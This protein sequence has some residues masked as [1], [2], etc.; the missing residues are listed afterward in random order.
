MNLRFPLIFIFFVTFGLF[1]PGV[2][3]A[4]GCCF[5]SFSADHGI[6]G[7]KDA[8]INAS[9]VDP[10]NI[11]NITDYGK[12]LVNEKIDIVIVNPKSGQSC[13]MSSPTTNQDGEV[14]ATCS[15]TLPGTIN[16]YFTAPD[17]EQ[18]YSDSI[19]YGKREIIFD[20]GS[21]LPGATASP[22]QTPSVSPSPTANPEVEELKNKVLTL[23]ET[24]SKQGKQVSWLTSI[25]QRIIKSLGRLFHF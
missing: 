24:V 9:F 15:S 1:F 21:G 25:V 2:V 17:L 5:K 11:G 3:H 8:L 6:A 16:I 19:S 23:E 22:E 20:P 4:G 13:K 12:P 7:E 14:V 10:R 18:Q